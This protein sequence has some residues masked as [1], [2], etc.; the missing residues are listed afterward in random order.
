[1]KKVFLDNLPK[2]GKSENRVDW[3]S[4][5][6][7][8]VKFIYNE[9]EGMLPILNYIK[10]GE[11]GFVVTEYKENKNF[12]IWIGDFTRGKLGV[13]LGEHKVNFIYEIED[14]IEN[15]KNG[16]LKIL[17]KI[18]IPTKGIKRNG[19]N[20]IRQLKGYKYEC[21]ICGDKREKT[22]DEIKRNGCNVCAG[23]EISKGYNDLWTKRP[24]VARLLKY[25]EKG[26]L[27]GLGSGSSEEIFICPICN[28]EQSQ[29]LNNVC[30]QGFS[31][32]I[33][34]DG[35]SYPEKF[36]SNVL[37]QIGIKFKKS[38]TFNWS[39]NV[40]HKNNKL[41]GKK[42]YD[43]YIPSLNMI[44]ETHGEQHYRYCG[45]ERTLEEEQEN[46]RLKEQLAMNNGIKNYITIDC[47]KS[48]LEFIKHNIL[49]SN[50]VNFYD[51]NKIDWEICNKNSTQSTVKI[52]CELWEEGNSIKEISKT[53]HIH[54]GTIRVY[55][56]K[57][58]KMGWSSYDSKVSRKE[59]YIVMSKNASKNV[60]KLDLQ[61]KLIDEY[62]SISLASRVNGISAGLIIGVCKGKHK[63]SGGFKWMYKEDYERYIENEYKQ[64]VK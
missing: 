40:E 35:I 19:E 60:V 38:K 21:L 16:K 36:M 30:K 29:I 61:G 51:L 28:S 4:T 37:T 9:V 11:R 24:D 32:K 1:M 31:C 3:R 44:I 56:K 48:D 55:L 49:N 27:V 39:K 57:G 63:T 47:R 14:I 8:N 59:S 6:G 45:F 12:E 46:D 13:L 15:G 42:I 25:P 2:Q 33:C 52:A 54:E 26:Y 5:I 53:L 17:E 43:F 41:S 50:L 10:K 7:Y 34:G 58:A 18:R 20:F 23:H 64:L 22:E 62:E